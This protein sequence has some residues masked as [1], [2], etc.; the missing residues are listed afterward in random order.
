[1]KTRILSYLLVAAMAIA[2]TSCQSDLE[3]RAAQFEKEEQAR[4]IV[5]TGFKLS[6]KST[7]IKTV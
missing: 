7:A 3:R 6:Y 2:G 1:M 4:G 5:L